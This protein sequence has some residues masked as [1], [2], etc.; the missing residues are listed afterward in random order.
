MYCRECGAPVRSS[1]AQFCRE[2]GCRLS[3]NRTSAPAALSWRKKIVIFA[4]C[5]AGVVAIVLIGASASSGG[6]SESGRRWVELQRPS[7]SARAPSPIM[8]SKNGSDDSFAGAAKDFYKRNQQQIDATAIGI[9]GAWLTH[10]LT[11]PDP[12]PRSAYDP[13][14]HSR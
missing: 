2:C 7:S 4:T 8:S 5:L 1:K 12:Q 13:A 3:Q 11:K 14:E 6:G 10:E 9:A